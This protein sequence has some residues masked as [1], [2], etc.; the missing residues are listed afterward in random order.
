MGILQLPSCDVNRSRRHGT[1]A[2][3]H[4]RTS[5]APASRNVSAISITVLPVVITSSTTVS[6]VGGDKR[7]PNASKR[8]SRRCSALRS[9]CGAVWRRRYTPARPASAAT[10]TAR[11]PGCSRAGAGAAHAAAPAP[12]ARTTRRWCA[13]H[14]LGKQA[15]GRQ[16]LVELVTHQQLIDGWKV[17]QAGMCGGLRRR[18]RQLPQTIRAASGNGSAQ[19]RQARPAQ[20]SS[21]RQARHRSRSSWPG[22]PHTRQRSGSSTRSA[23]C[24][25]R[26]DLNRTGMHYSVIAPRPW[27]HQTLALQPVGILTRLR[28]T[29]PRGRRRGIH[30]RAV[31]HVRRLPPINAAIESA[32]RCS[33]LAVKY[34]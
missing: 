8:L 27:G 6:R 2:H 30:P 10:G 17:Q 29:S 23:A 19:R 7:V 15:P 25:R 26:V 34:R 32:C 20:G 33:W 3:T 13:L 14:Q 18:S 12:A 22:S 5:L 11:R 31:H 4:A 24:R 28:I 21:A 9:D 16:V 1:R